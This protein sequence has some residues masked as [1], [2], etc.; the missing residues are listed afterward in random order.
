[1]KPIHIY[2]ILYYTS[3]LSAGVFPHMFLQKLSSRFARFLYS[4]K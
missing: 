4:D 1:M 3:G 2:T